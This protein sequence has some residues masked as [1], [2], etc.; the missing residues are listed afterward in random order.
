[1]T[2]FINAQAKGRHKGKDPKSSNLNPKES[3]DPS[4][5]SLGSKKKKKFEKTKC[6]Y[7]MRGFHPDN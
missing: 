5:G 4:E 3:Q 1:M 6:H 7:C 2:N